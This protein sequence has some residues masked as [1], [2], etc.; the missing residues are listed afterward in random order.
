V[1]NTVGFGAVGALIGAAAGGGTGAAIG[2]G[3]GA[4]AGLAN[5]AASPRGQIVV[6]PESVLTFRTAAPTAVR[7]V[8]EAEM[9]RLSYAA[10]PQRQGPPPQRRYYSRRYGYY[11]GPAY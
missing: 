3:I 4:G 8:S 1:N 10:G 2:A 6:L 9:S 11:Y 7:T 5:S